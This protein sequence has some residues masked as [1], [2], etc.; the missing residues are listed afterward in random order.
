MSQEN[1][2]KVRAAIDAMNRGEFAGALEVHP[3]VEWQTLDVFPDTGTYRGP[4]AVLE[5]FRAGGRPFKALRCILRTASQW[6]TRMSSP[7]CG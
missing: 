5:F 1:V 4:E 6:A 7:P 2:E 3:D